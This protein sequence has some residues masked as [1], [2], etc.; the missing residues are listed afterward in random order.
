MLDPRGKAFL[1]KQKKRAFDRI[2]NSASKYVLMRKFNSASRAG[3]REYIDEGKI[4]IIDTAFGKAYALISRT[5]V[6]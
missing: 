2:V 6:V 5:S 4:E 1:D 3:L